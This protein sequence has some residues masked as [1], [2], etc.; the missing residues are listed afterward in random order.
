M[1]SNIEM[2]AAS[3]DAEKEMAMTEMNMKMDMREM[4]KG[5]II[6]FPR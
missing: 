1:K 2:D 3:K 5:N 4:H 6:I